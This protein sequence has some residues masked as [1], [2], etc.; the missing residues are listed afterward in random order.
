MDDIK[1]K[2]K[3]FESFFQVPFNIDLENYISPLKD[4]LKRMLSDSN[5]LFKNYGEFTYFTAMKD[6]KA[7]GRVTAHIHNKSNEKFDTRTGYFGH[8][9]CENDLDTARALMNK[10][11]S[12]LK[13]KG[14]KTIKGAFNLTAMQQIGVMTEGFENEPYTDQ[15][16]SPSFT[17]DLLKKLGFDAV[18][19]MRTYEI[20][21]EKVQGIELIKDKHKAIISSGDYT[22]EKI[23]F[24]NTKECLKSVMDILNDGFSENPMFVPLTFEEFYFQAKDM[25]WI[26]DRHIACIIKHN[27]DP[28]G[29]IMCIPDLNPFLKK[30]SS[31]MGLKAP[32]HFI[33]N[34]LKRDRAVI[35]FYSVKKEM[36]GKGLNAIM[37][38]YVFK[39]LFKR[40]YKTCGFT[41]I[42]E[43]NKP[44]V[45]QADKLLANDMHKLHLFEKEL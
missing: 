38:D 25:M 2:E 3:D 43:I 42:A 30:I 9:E 20:D 45:A 17:Q 16:Y 7:V 14:M 34:K 8:F 4:D 21:V 12:W 44:S 39:N 27:G 35:I 15:N 13:E 24:F 37:L 22:F 36:H 41:W 23:N 5:P 32:Y 33:K 31:K 11:E 28:V 40:G 29:T 1:I 26:I 19:P 6:N 18:F 10:A